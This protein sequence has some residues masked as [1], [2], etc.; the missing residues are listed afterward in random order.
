MALSL[1]IMPQRTSA[2]PQSTDDKTTT[3]QP[4]NTKQSNTDKEPGLDELLG[5]DE[6]ESDVGAKGKTGL[7]DI[8][9]SLNP[10]DEQQGPP[11]AKLFLEAI[12]AMNSSADRLNNEHD[13]GLVT[14]RMQEDALLKLAA[15][16]KQAQKQ[17]KKSKQ[18]G[19][20]E[21]QQKKQKPA[22]QK[23]Q[24]QSQQKNPGD[25]AATTDSRPAGRQTD[26]TGNISENNTEWGNLPARVRDLLLQGSNESSALLYRHLTELYYK[27]LAEE[28]E[29]KKQ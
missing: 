28:A 6:N 10:E 11:I 23:K 26:L 27:R 19:K 8:N 2:Y 22:N 4:Q 7:P 3:D 25:Q 13:P 9:K 24:S 16:I 18:S 21:Q 29:K 5:L 1:F 15:L 20:Q 17:G 12:Q 14:Q